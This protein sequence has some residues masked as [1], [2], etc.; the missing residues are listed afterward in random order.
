MTA[1]ASKRELLAGLVA[2]RKTFTP[3]RFAAGHKPQLC[4]IKDRSPWIHVLCDRQSGK[5]WGDIGMMADNATRYPGSPNV[6]LGLKGTGINFSVWE[7]LWKPLCEKYQLKVKLNNTIMLAKFANGSRAIFA[8]TDDLSNVK[9]YLGNRLKNGLFIIDESQDQTDQVLTYLLKT[10]LPP[11]LTPT[12]RVVLSGVLPDTPVG[13][14][15]ALAERDEASGTGGK[16]K[17]WSH[18]GWGRF[19]NVHTPEAR[20]QLAKYMRDHD[21]DENDPQIQRDWLG[22]KRVW[23]LKATAYKYRPERNGYDPTRPT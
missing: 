22:C 13:L 14:F 19:S 12:S 16:G 2:H 5:T 15:L 18:H 1:V 20:E 9:K 6:F 7:P 11:M 4:L 23:D 17:G 3:E 10:L 21:I 8:G